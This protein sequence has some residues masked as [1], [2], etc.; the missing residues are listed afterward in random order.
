MFADMKNVLC[1]LTVFLMCA[2]SYGATTVTAEKKEVKV[3]VVGVGND[4]ATIAKAFHDL[5]TMHVVVAEQVEKLTQE[6]EAFKIENPYI[7]FDY[8]Y[9]PIME[10]DKPKHFYTAVSNWKSTKPIASKAKTFRKARDAI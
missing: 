4:I 1:L 2:V 10:T 9:I 8:D 5:G 6:V 3:L 7:G